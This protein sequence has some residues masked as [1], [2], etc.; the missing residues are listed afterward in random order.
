[1]F[2]GSLPESDRGIFIFY[3]LIK[4]LHH[5]HGVISILLFPVQMKNLGKD[6]KNFYWMLLGMEK[7]VVME[8][9]AS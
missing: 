4:F 5:C 6:Q 1:M 7:I 8:C 9:L 2:F 3:F